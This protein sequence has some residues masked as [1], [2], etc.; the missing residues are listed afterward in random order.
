MARNRGV[1]RRYRRPSSS[2]LHR[3]RA[4]HVRRNLFGLQASFRDLS[5]AYGIGK[6]G[7]NAAPKV[8]LDVLHRLKQEAR[9]A[10]RELRAKMHFVQRDSERVAEQRA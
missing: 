5:A 9:A 10:G 4:S 1:T 7:R 6:G 2:E 3:N 8:V